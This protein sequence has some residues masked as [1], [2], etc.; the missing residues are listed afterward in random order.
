MGPGERGLST[1]AGRHPAVT[2]V[3]PALNEAANLPTVLASL[4]GDVFEVVLV[5]GRSQDGTIDIARRCRPDVRIVEQTGH[6]K[7][8]AL[9]EGFAAARGE[10]IVMFDADGSAK[11]DEIPRFVQALR[12]GADLAKG[13]RFTGDGGS[14]DIT[15]SRRLGNRV[16]RGIVNLL[17][18]TRYTDLCYGF[19]AIWSRCVPSLDLESTGF[20]FETLLNIRAAKAGLDV[21]EVP[22]Y[23]NQR[24]NGTSNLNAVRDGVRIL[25]LILHERLEYGRRRALRSDVRLL[26]PEPRE[27]WSG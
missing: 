15:V 7:G 5:D 8:N 20:E 21:C 25:R 16:L 17:F 14:A 23:E 27:P 3:I 12:E 24:L 19:N 13:S 1:A 9:L 11:G 22:S 2:V 6:G 4:P 18:H 10:I 26:A